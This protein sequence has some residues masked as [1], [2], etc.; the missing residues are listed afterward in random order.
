MKVSELRA[1]L[2]KR[3]MDSTGLKAQLLKRLEASFA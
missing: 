2:S 3:G 1:E